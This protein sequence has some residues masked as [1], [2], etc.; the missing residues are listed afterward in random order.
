MCLATTE[1]KRGLFE[2]QTDI[3]VLR[4]EF[5]DA[6]CAEL[7]DI[8]AQIKDKAIELCPKES[9]ALASSIELE[10]EGGSG[11]T[12]VSA[13]TQGGEFYR[14]AIFAGN[15]ET[16]NFDG[17]PTSQYVAAVH[18]GHVLPNGDFWE[19]TPF[20]EDAVDAF[21]DELNSIVDK[22]LNSLEIGDS[23][24]PSTYKLGDE[25]Y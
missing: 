2:T 12:G 16:F 4:D 13:S 14:N 3:R 6:V 1:V 21:E 11:K 8:W 22:A 20:L 10:S 19:G 7:D 25:T 5:P 24:N 23:N 15:D 9:G 17:Q 18:D